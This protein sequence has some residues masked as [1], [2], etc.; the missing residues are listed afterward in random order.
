MKV[1]T[2]ADSGAE[3]R[4]SG[5]QMGGSVVQ[6]RLTQAVRRARLTGLSSVQVKKQIEIR[7]CSV[8]DHLMCCKNHQK[9]SLDPFDL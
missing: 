1:G 6:K 4:K 9:R 2:L 3:A 5:S 8:L 7:V